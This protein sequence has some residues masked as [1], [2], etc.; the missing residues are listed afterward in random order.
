MS[1]A[2]IIGS[3]LIDT[4]PHHQELRA[5]VGKLVGGF[6]RAYFQDVVR[7]DVKPVELWSALGDAGYLGVHIPAEHGGGGGGLADLNVVIEET[8]AQ[9]CPMLAMVINS[10]CADHHGAWFRRIE[11]GVAPR[12]CAGHQADVVRRDRTRCR[13]QHPPHQHHGAP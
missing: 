8:A 4:A 10:I 5:S 3:D 6:G 11:A 7:R 13:H 2:A 9:G 12:S 1:R